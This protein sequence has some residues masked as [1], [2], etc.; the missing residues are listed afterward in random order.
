M[1]RFLPDEVEAVVARQIYVYAEEV[2]ELVAGDE[3]FFGA[4]GDDAATFHHD[5]ALDL[6]RDVREQVGDQ[7]DAD[8]VARQLAEQFAQLALGGDVERVGGLIEQ[9][10]LA[11]LHQGTADHGA[12]LLAGGHL[13]HGLRRQMGCIKLLHY[14]GSALAHRSSHGEIG[15]ERGAGEEAGQHSIESSG[16]AR[17]AAG[18]FGGDDAE[19]LLQL[20]QVPALAAEDADAH[21]GRDQRIALAGHGLDECGFTAAVGPENGDVLARLDAQVDVVQNDIVAT[22]DADMFEEKEGLGGLRGHL[23]KNTA[24]RKRA[25]RDEPPVGLCWL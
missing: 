1:L 11:G 22:C 14:G 9:K 12:A 3:L 24:Q 4:V 23:F 21:L 18:E 2:A 20:G 16:G 6:G 25:T 5:D 10:H 17:L 15:P 8:A 19:A 7:Q 13:A